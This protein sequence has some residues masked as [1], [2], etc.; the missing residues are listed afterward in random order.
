MF[1]LFKKKSKVQKLEDNYKKLMQEWHKYS[2]IN[3]SKSDEKFA[4]AQKILEEIES[5]KNN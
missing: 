3:R 1:N 4:E 2:S 5:L